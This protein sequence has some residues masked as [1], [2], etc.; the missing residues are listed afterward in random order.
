MP[1]KKKDKKNSTTHNPKKQKI[2]IKFKLPPKPASNIEG[3]MSAAFRNQN[4]PEPNQHA[5]HYKNPPLHKQCFQ[6][7]KK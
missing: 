7:L 2:K 1:S 4:Q 3:Q 6:L 5:N